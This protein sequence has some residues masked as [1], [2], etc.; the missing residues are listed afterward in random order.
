MNFAGLIIMCAVFG[1]IFY[2]RHQRSKRKYDN[3]ALYFEKKVAAMNSVSEADF[4]RK[5]TAMRE[6]AAAIRAD[7]DGV[8]HD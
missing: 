7:A 5:M 1:L 2:S 3:P 4:D 6:R 8:D